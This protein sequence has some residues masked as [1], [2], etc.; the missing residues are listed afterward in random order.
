MDTLAHLQLLLAAVWPPAPGDET[1]GF[2]SIA[3]NVGHTIRN[4][5]KGQRAECSAV[6]DNIAQIYI[7][8][9]TPFYLNG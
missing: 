8:D 1:T 3:I 9:S 7:S 4:Q 6:T 5:W 2:S